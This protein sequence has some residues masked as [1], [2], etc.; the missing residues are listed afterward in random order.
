MNRMIKIWIYSSIFSAMVGGMWW[1]VSKYYEH[2]ASQNPVIVI[3][4]EELSSIY[5]SDENSANS[6]Y[7]SRV[8]EITGVISSS[9]VNGEGYTIILDGNVYD[10][11]CEFTDDVEIMN[12]SLLNP[13]DRVTLKGK[14]VGMSLLNI[15]LEGCQFIDIL[16]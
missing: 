11:D 5:L 4:A 13:G 14:V 6:E 10:I 2:K 1:G 9:R 3:T 8:L 7:R 12:V 15:V 16:D